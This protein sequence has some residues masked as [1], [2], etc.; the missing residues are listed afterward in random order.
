MVVFSTGCTS[1]GSGVVEKRRGGWDGEIELVRANASLRQSN[2][3]LS[4]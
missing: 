2:G 1:S 4:S 3:S